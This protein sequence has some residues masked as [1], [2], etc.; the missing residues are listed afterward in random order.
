M[1][2]PALREGGGRPGR[3]QARTVRGSERD[4]ET[5][6]TLSFA[7]RNLG[8]DTCGGLGTPRGRC[9]GVSG[10][11]DPASVENRP[12]CALEGVAASSGT[13]PDG[14]DRRCAPRPARDH[15]A[16]RPI[17]CGMGTR[18]LRRRRC[19]ES[20]RRTS[21]L[22][23]TPTFRRNI[24]CPFPEQWVARSDSLGTM[25]SAKGRWVEC[26]RRW[27]GAAAQPRSLDWATH[28]LRNGHP[29]SSA[30][31]MCRVDANDFQIT[32]P[33]ADREPPRS[34]PTPTFFRRRRRAETTRTTSNTS[35]SAANTRDDTN[36]F[37]HHHPADGD[38]PIRRA[39]AHR[40]RRQ[41]SSCRIG[42]APSTPTRRWSRPA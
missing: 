29:P 3:A 9:A 23:P 39:A 38:P 35:I 32:P 31:A 12:S 19:A 20:T 2:A 6:P 37:Q 11:R 28:C 40:P 18:R 26:E 10:A 24:G 30:A 36:D 22:R 15:W 42:S 5:H 7:L 17:A 13:R 1:G 14:S 33:K 27:I 8:R 21:E 34:R 4:P 41:T 25:P 16:R